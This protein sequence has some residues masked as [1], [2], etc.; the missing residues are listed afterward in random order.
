MVQFNSKLWKTKKF[1]K[2]FTLI[3]PENSKKNWPRH[4]ISSTAKQPKTRSQTYLKW[5]FK[6]FSLRWMPLK[7]LQ[8]IEFQ[9]I[10]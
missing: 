6:R 5:L 7:L 8:W 9:Q 4:P 10:F 1:S 3:K 2:D